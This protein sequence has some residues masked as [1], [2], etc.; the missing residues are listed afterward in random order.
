MVRDPDFTGTT[1]E[2]EGVP[3]TKGAGFALRAQ[4]NHPEPGDVLILANG[5]ARRESES[6]L[7]AYDVWRASRRRTGCTGRSRRR[8]AKKSGQ[9]L[10]NG[11]WKFDPRQKVQPR[12][13]GIAVFRPR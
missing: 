13:A 1:I 11:A 6:V 9:S 7:W 2:L 3:L 4:I 5:A 12:P 10:G 8:I